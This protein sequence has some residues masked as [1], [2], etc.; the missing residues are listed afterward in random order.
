MDGPFG[1]SLVVL[2]SAGTEPAS[3]A[4]RAAG[5]GAPVWEAAALAGRLVEVAAPGRAAG[6]AL[7]AA[8]S[9][10]WKAQQQGE[11]TAWVQAG[12]TS[13][14]PP[15]FAAGGIDLDALA[16]VRVAGAA[17]AAR[18][19][20]KLLRS[21]GFGLVVLD[22]GAGARLPPALVSRLLGLALQ[23]RAAVVFLTGQ[24]ARG[25]DA[26]SLSPLVSLRVTVQ[27]RRT[28]NSRFQCCIRAIKDKRR[29][30][31]WTIEESFRGPPGLR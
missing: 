12:P 5:D 25:S 24:A 14:F 10:V 28:G 3:E 31:G 17:A 29:A 27:A 23:H 21:G 18:A 19:A 4:G 2:P 11:V 8:S 7:T 6:A 26:G 22:L 20:D 16:V 30:P 9:L 15:D 1:Q 13:F